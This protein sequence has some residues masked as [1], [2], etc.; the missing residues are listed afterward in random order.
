MFF[1]NDEIARIDADGLGKPTTSKELD[2]SQI[3]T[4]LDNRARDFRAILLGLLAGCIALTVA[5]ANAAVP[6][7]DAKYDHFTDCNSYWVPLLYLAIL[8]VLA[9]TA[10][11][12]VGPEV[13]RV[14]K[15]GEYIRKKYILNR[16][17]VPIIDGLLPRSTQ[18]EDYNEDERRRRIKEGQQQT[19]DGKA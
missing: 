2:P 3:Y 7:M 17:D 11:F 4:L 15:R 1:K 19:A 5:S 13:G 8:C 12:V 18:L 16:D 10:I 14:R 9:I 6:C